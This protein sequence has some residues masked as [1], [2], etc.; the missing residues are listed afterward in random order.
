MIQK[1]IDTTSELDYQKIYDTTFNK[2]YDDRINKLKELFKTKD[3]YTNKKKFTI[4]TELIAHEYSDLEQGADGSTDNYVH[5]L[6][7]KFQDR[8]DNY[9]E[10]VIKLF[11]EKEVKILQE[12]YRTNSKS[13][14]IIEEY[15]EEDTLV[16][17]ATYLAIKALHYDCGGIFPINTDSGEN[18]LNQIVENAKKRLTFTIPAKK[19]LYYWKYKESELQKLYQLLLDG[20]FTHSDPSFPEYSDPSKSWVLFGYKPIFIIFSRGLGSKMRG[21]NF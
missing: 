20:N 21:V 13:K 5:Y 3:G 12:Q 10:D 6:V 19:E 9:E 16:F 4:F 7:K 17:L 15:N 14:L 8:Y 1:N 18:I 11:F 2:V